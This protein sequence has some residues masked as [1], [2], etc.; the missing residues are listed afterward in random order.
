MM[1]KRKKK[2]INYTYH[3]VSTKISSI[4][5]EAGVPLSNKQIQEQLLNKYN[6]NL[7]LANLTK[8]ILP[9]VRDDSN[10]FVEKVYRGFWQYRVQK[11]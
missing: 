9:R 11:K 4:L 7:K 1:E 8:N 5:K 6:I 3:E 10:F 2:P